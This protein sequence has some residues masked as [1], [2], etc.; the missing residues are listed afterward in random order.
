MPDKPFFVY[1]APGATHAPH[2]V[3][4]EWS[5][6]YKGAFDDGWDALRE[7]TLARQKELGVIPPDAEL[8]PTARRDPGV[9]R[10]ARRSQAGARAADGGLRRVP[11]AHRLPH[12]SPHRCP[13]RARHPRQHARLLH[14]R[15][16]RRIGRGHPPRDIQ[17][18]ARPQRRESVRDHRV[19]GVQD[20]SV[21]DSG[22]VQPLRGRLGPCH[23]HPVPVDQAGCQPLG[24]DTQRHDRVVAE[25]HRGERRDPQPVPP[26]DRRRAHDPRSSRAARP[27]L[28]QRD[29]AGAARGRL[30]GVFVRR[31]RGRRPAHDAVLRDVRQPR[32]LPPGLDGGD[33]SFDARG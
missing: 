27:D 20:R 24:R 30:D 25:R 15:R 18:A 4:T 28:R 9:G 32:H 11:R 8:T 26:R 12:G 17:R 22:G 33:A 23:G 10:H 6:K 2:H 31:R 7:Q 21:R 16:Q 14:H 13:G 5:A 19:H 3:P 29:P 1:W